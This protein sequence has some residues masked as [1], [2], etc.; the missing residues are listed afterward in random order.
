M[1]GSVILLIF[2]RIQCL[3]VV[4]TDLFSPIIPISE[5]QT[6]KEMLAQHLERGG[7]NVSG[8]ERRWEGG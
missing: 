4:G 8:R 7:C 6:F 5:A 1:P 3:R 2:D